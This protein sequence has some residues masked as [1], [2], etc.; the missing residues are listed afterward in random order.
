VAE[1]KAEIK[2]ELDAAIAKADA[3]IA[4]RSAEAEAEIAGIRASAMENVEI[5]ARDTAQAIVASMGGTADAS[6]IDAAVAG[7]VKG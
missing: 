3:E 2:S 5:V 1:T 6:A 4:A 7:R